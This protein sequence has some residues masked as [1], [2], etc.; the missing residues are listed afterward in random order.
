MKNFNQQVTEAIRS[1]VELENG[2]GEYDT[3]RKLSVY[4]QATKVLITFALAKMMQDNEVYAG[5]NW[6]LAINDMPLD[7][8]QWYLRVKCNG[9]DSVMGYDCCLTPGHPGLCFSNNKHVDFQK[10]DAH[11]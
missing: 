9:R 10:E 3:F 2:E 11:A 4:R 7:R 8:A 6:E 1:V 5:D